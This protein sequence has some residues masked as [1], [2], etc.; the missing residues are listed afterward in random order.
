ML[1]LLCCGTRFR[2]Y[3]LRSRI[4][5]CP[6]PLT[7][8][9][10]TRPASFG[11]W[12]SVP[13]RLLKRLY[14]LL[15]SSSCNLRLRSRRRPSM[16]LRLP[17]LPFQVLLSEVPDCRRLAEPLLPPLLP[18]LAHWAPD[19]RRP[20]VPLRGMEE[21][22]P[23]A[24]LLKMQSFFAAI[25]LCVAALPVSPVAVVG[26]VSMLPVHG[27][28]EHV[29]GDEQM[30]SV[31]SRALQHPPPMQLR[32]WTWI[33]VDVLVAHAAHVF[34]SG[35]LNNLVTCTAPALFAQ[36]MPLVLDRSVCTVAGLPVI[37]CGPP[38]LRGHLRRH[39]LQELLA[40]MA[41][42]GGPRESFRGLWRNRRRLPLFILRGPNRSIQALCRHLCNISLF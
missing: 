40:P 29:R 31:A 2:A 6:A 3:V 34:F 36:Y 4:F 12:C 25:A 1:W 41:L 10:L 22:G 35:A 28:V 27:T 15:S 32:R 24:P 30:P 5:N 26:I 23:H 13:Y 42:P 21:R 14:G 38:T 39:S 17:P 37:L 11:S 16:C 19:C 20:V 9:S 33:P 7:S 18:S 8:I